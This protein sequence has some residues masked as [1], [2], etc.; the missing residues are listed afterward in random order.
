VTSTAQGMTGSG[1]SKT[2]P[3]STSV[4]QDTCTEEYEYPSNTRYSLVP[5]STAQSSSQLLSSLP[6][7]TSA[8]R[9]KLH[10]LT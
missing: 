9:G 1:L 8:G 4:P 2:L 7:S 5:T 6:F 3:F 10:F